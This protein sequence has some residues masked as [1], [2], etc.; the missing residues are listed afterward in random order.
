MIVLTCVLGVLDALGNLDFLFAREQRDLAH[1]LEIH[2]DRIV[3]DIR[4]P[5]FL[6]LPRL[7]GLLDAID[8]GLVDDLD[9]E[10]AELDVDLIEIVGSD[11][12]IRQSIVDIVVG[13]VALFL[14]EADEFLDFFGQIDA[15]LGFNRG[16][17]S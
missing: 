6:P 7:L 12:V 11:D 5:S 17:D 14:G 3:E 2:A 8:F 4:R 1:L 10:I 16:Q 9:L 13:E 15:G